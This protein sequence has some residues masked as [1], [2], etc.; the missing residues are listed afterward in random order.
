MQEESYTELFSALKELHI[1][2]MKHSTVDGDAGMYTPVAI[3]TS[4]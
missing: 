4:N 2:A 1:L 3:V